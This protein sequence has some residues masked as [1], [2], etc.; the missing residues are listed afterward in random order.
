MYQLSHT[1]D[2]SMLQ[3][4]SHDIPKMCSIKL[5]DNAGKYHEKTLIIKHQKSISPLKRGQIQLPADQNM[6]NVPY[7]YIMRRGIHLF[8]LPATN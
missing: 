1:F 3:N 7:V 4:I 8:T 2:R 5:S 6:S